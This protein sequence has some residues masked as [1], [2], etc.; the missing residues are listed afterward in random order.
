MN[1]ERQK[2]RERERERERDQG[3]SVAKL[4]PN[5]RDNPGYS[6]TS[7]ESIRPAFTGRIDGTELAIVVATY[8]ARPQTRLSLPR[9][10][11][12]PFTW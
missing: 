3:V 9:T 2:E 10:F 1:K 5:L 4:S 12:R 11:R 6:A 7:K 8:I